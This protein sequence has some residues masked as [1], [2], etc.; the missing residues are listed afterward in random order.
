MK[1]LG[2]IT[3]MMLFLFTQCV[4]DQETQTLEWQ[5]G[6][7]SSEYDNLVAS[8][9]GY[10]KFSMSSESFCVGSAYITVNLEVDGESLIHENV[11]HFPFTKEFAISAGDNISI[12][13]KV[14]AKVIQDTVCVR[15][16]NVN[17]KL[18]Y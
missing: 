7:V 17:C 11:Y 16:G 10:L 12:N 4:K 8:N 2:F 1:N 18:D 15:L 3:I 14:V 9:N 6:E 13:T 5:V